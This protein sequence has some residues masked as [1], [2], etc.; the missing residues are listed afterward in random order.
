V[1]IENLTRLQRLH[2]IGKTL[3]PGEKG[4]KIPV[5]RVTR[6]T[7]VTF[8]TFVTLGMDKIK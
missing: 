6:V 1:K 7:P 4:P 3:N 2:T 5:T 8:V